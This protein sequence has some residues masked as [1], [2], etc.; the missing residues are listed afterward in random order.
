MRTCF[1]TF[2]YIRTS[3]PWQLYFLRYV[4][5]YPL[6]CDCT[7]GARKKSLHPGSIVTCCT[8]AGLHTIGVQ[9]DAL[10]TGISRQMCIGGVEGSRYGA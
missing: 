5:Q 4:R 1:D 2:K 9:R 6:T 8:H 10:A 3:T 7:L